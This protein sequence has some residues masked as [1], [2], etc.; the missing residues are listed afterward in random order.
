M[1]RFFGGAFLSLA[2]ICYF[3]A[4]VRILYSNI[5]TL[6]GLVEPNLFAGL[7]DQMG[8]QILGPHFLFIVI[9]VAT[10]VFFQ[11]VSDGIKDRDWSAPWS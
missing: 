9:H 3:F 6:F 8:I 2:Y 7:L 4:L 5:G 11:W 10:G 1:R